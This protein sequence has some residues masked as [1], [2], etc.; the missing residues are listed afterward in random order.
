MT[1]KSEPRESD[2][3]PII[4]PPPLLFF[5]CLAA[6][7]VADL[8]HP[9]RIV[10]WGWTPRIFTACGFFLLSTLISV[11]SLR[12]FKAHSTSVNPSKPTTAIVDRATFRFSR[13]P[14]YISL[15]VGFVGFIAL[16]ASYW[17]LIL[18]PVLFALLHFGVVKREEVYL[19]EKFPDEYTQYKARVRRWI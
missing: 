3:A 16:L 8:V 9:L 14:L 2:R 15:L 11:I 13:N 17:L 12:T 6:G 1:D 5:G 10:D 7:Y 4:A 19:E 18:L